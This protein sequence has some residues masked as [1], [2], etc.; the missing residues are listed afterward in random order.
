MNA[1]RLVCIVAVLLL[2]TPV[3]AQE[4]G[5][6]LRGRLIDIAPNDSSTTIG[7]TGTGAAVDS[8]M[9]LEVDLTYKFNER[10]A[11]EVIA[12]TAKH[13]LTTESGALAGA[14]AGAVTHLPPTVTLQYHFPVTGAFHPYI[15]AGLNYTIFYD[16]EISS[17]LRGLGLSDLD[18]ENSFGL[19][20]QLG[21]DYDI[22][23]RWL[24]NVDLKYIKIST[25]V[26][27]ELEGGGVL[28][29]ITVDIDPW[30]FGVG[31]GY[32]F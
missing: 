6:V 21:F 3:M 10:W 22:N 16:Y 13:D 32:R 15:G 19:A 25:D 28:D 8:A 4:T 18:F 9:T 31:I 11:V 23:D 5:W 29:T 17:D 12:A 20:G 2:V 14:D 30:V 26:D 24:F 27:L 7:D 1:R